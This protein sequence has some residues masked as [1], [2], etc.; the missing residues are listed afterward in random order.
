MIDDLFFAASGLRTTQ[1][2]SSSR[3]CQHSHFQSSSRFY[4]FIDMAFQQYHQRR[5]GFPTELCSVAI[6]IITVPMML[7]NRVI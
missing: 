1:A 2:D 7:I 4:H 6:N 3:L 5:L